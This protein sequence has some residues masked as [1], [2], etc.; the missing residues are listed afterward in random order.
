MEYN[1]ENGQFI[2]KYSFDK[3]KIVKDSY[4][5]YWLLGL[6]ASDGNINNN[7]FSITQSKKC[8][9]DLIYYIKDQLNYNGVV[10]END[11]ASGNKSYSLTISSKDIVSYLSKYNIIKNKTYNFILPDIDSEE[12]FNY[13]IRGYF[14]GDGSVGIYDNGNGIEYIQSSIY[15]QKNVIEQIGEFI[16]ADGNVNEKKKGFA[17]IRYN[18]AEAVAFFNQIYSNAENDG[19]FV[20]KKYNIFK[21]YINTDF[22]NTVYY[23]SQMRKEKIQKLLNEGFTPYHIAKYKNVNTNFQTIYGWINKGELFYDK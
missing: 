13:F 5:K 22:K 21:K 3:S 17:E 18:G 14:E 23:D 19:I 10:Y 16:N 12:Y 7:T 6:L 1:K 2:K 11:T 15:G 8:G 20:G 9:K 4:F